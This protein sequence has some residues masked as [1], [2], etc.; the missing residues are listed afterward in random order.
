MIGHAILDVLSC[1]PV[2]RRDINIA[3]GENVSPILFDRV[4]EALVKNDRVGLCSPGVYG[5]T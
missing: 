3:V 4:L 1:G 2:S 5:L